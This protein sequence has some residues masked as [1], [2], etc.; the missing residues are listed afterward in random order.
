MSSVLTGSV[1]TDCLLCCLQQK[2]RYEDDSGDNVD[3]D[4]EADVDA[5]VARFKL[6]TKDGTYHVVH[7]YNR[8]S[9][10][11]NLQHPD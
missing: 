3:E 5:N 7:D 1:L 10:S 4:V 6:T 9:V 8:V 11:Q 2:L